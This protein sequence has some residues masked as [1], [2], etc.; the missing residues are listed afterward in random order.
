[1]HWTLD[2]VRDL[3]C[4]DY[5]ALVQWLKAEAEAA[6]SGGEPSMDWDAM[7]DAKTAKRDIQ[8]WHTRHAK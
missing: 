6:K 3:D 1:M 7:M 8:E 5:D 4:E 2:Q